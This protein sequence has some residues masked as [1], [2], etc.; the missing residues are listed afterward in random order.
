M[1]T[2]LETYFY[3]KCIRTYTAAFGTLFNNIKIVRKDGKTIKVPLAYASRQKFDI[4]EKKENTD[5]H[6]KT[7]H[8]RLAFNFIGMQRDDNRVEN[9]RI[10][11]R[12]G[13]G[14]QVDTQL[15][16]VPYTFNYEVYLQAKHLDDLFQVVEQICAWFNPSL[17]IFIEDNPDLNQTTSINVKLDTES[18]TDSFEGLMED[19][20]ILNFTFQF[21]V[22]GYLYMPTE[23]HGTIQ[24]I[25]LNYYDLDT[26]VLYETDQIVP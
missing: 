5:A 22:E 15:N 10:K 25:T 14:L 12:E 4:A 16:R 24:Q 9:K 26:E 23:Q 17:D 3:H 7:V 19:T 21:T 6:I 13:N 11:L 20:K 18:M 2:A 1:A 8:P